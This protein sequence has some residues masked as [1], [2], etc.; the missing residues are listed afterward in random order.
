MISFMQDGEWVRTV[1]AVKESR[2][3]VVQKRAGDSVS[4]GIEVSQQ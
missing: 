2:V 1:M 4:N 3:R